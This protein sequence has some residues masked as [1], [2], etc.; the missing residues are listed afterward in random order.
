MK[1]NTDLQQRFLN[2]LKTLVPDT[3]SF[4]DK[5]ADLL[6]ISTDSVYR[7]LRG[8][9]SLTL[10]E[11]TI[12]CEHFKIS[13]DMFAERETGIV[14]FNYNS[15]KNEA[16]F[17]FWLQ[18]ILYEMNNIVKS[19][20]AHITYSAIDVPVFHHFHFPN[21]AEFKIFY[22]LKA[23]VNEPSFQGKKFDKALIPNELK[24]LGKQIYD[25][26]LK[27]PSTEIWTTETI[28][29]T[30]KQIEFYWDSG[31][32]Q[33]SD[34]AILICQDLIKM[35]ENIERFAERSS[36]DAMH[37]D[38]FTLY[39]SEIEVGNNSIFV[40]KAETYITFLTFHTFNK[41]VTDNS[42]FCSETKMW[43]ENIIKKSVPL[44]GVSQKQRY[45]FF[46]KAF[47]KINVLIEKIKNEE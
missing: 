30:I 32:F 31:M 19:N 14:T 44:S 47:V 20:P 6:D 3:L 26:Y 15:L 45:Q 7:R 35:L 22:W 34:E 18:S 41:L 24:H 42:K 43:I 16:E 25:V 38:N 39:Q 4:V 17:K 2:R 11:V 23:V 40:Q 10:D 33:T 27:I 37:K 21:L 13:F 8:E 29:S 36:K 5:L 46:K 28:N 12:L 1:K 9:T